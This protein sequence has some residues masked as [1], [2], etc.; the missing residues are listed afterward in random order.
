MPPANISVLGHRFSPDC[1]PLHFSYTAQLVA[2]DYRV[3]RNT[4]G[5]WSGLEDTHRAERE[6][7]GGFWVL[8][9]RC[10][11]QMN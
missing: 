10:G 4:G 6:S 7:T 3:Q 8:Q 11:L 2:L 5:G 1:H 9:V